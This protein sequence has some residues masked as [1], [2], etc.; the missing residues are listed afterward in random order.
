M[1]VWSKAWSLFVLFMTPCGVSTGILSFGDGIV[2]GAVGGGCGV[3]GEFDKLALCV[4]VFC[5]VLFF[6]FCFFLSLFLPFSFLPPLPLKCGVGNLVASYF[7]SLSIWL[8]FQ[9]QM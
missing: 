8:M 5:F 9:A 3:W 4:C 7:N 2:V 6:C 1:S